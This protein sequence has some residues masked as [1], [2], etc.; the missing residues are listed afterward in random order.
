M[1]MKMGLAVLG[2]VFLLCGSTTLL[3]DE[4]PMGAPIAVAKIVSVSHASPYDTHITIQF[5]RDCSQSFAGIVLQPVPPFSEHGPS[6]LAVL[7]V[8]NGHDCHGTV[9]DSVTQEFPA[10]D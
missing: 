9:T 7:L 10:P 3:A 5:E 4:I 1:K 8:G 2:L 6:A